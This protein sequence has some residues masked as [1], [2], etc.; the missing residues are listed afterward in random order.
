LHIVQD[1]MLVC[2]MYWCHMLV[3]AHLLGVNLNTQTE[4]KNLLS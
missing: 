1:H 3:S 2:K 4:P